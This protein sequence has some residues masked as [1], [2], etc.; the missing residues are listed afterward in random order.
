MALFGFFCA[1]AVFSG[2]Y[3]YFCIR[4]VRPSGIWYV[5]TGSERNR[6]QNDEKGSFFWFSEWIQDFKKGHFLLFLALFLT[7]WA[8]E[9]DRG[10]TKETIVGTICPGNMSEQVRSVRSHLGACGGEKSLL[11]LRRFSAKMTTWSFQHF[12]WE[13]EHLQQ[14]QNGHFHGILAPEGDLKFE[15]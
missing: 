10:K 15:K 3:E 4:M 14:P 13:N 1:K 2:K 11:R 8:V 7:K 5:L 6:A 12:F 9:A